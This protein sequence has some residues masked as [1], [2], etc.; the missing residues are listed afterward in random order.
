MIQFTPSVGVAP[1]TTTLGGDLCMLG[2]CAP[3]YFGPAV[4]LPGSAPVPQPLAGRF[5]AY[6]PYA[7][8]AR[9]TGL[10]GST[11]SLGLFVLT[12]GLGFAGVLGYSL[13]KRR[14]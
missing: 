9:L 3:G 10:R 11:S 2:E 1:G 4:M 13:W 8:E 14:K 5:I 6:N 12:L 7:S